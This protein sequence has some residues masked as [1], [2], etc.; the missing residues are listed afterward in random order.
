MTGSRRAPTLAAALLLLA[1]GCEKKAAAPVAGAEWHGLPPLAET[2]PAAAA[3]HPATGAMPAGHPPIGDSP[4]E[5]AP[6]P[7]A[8]DPQSMI[9]GVLRLD[10]KVKS[11]VA[12]GDTIFMVARAAD[13]SGAPGPILAVKKLNASGWPLA[14]SLDGRDAMTAG[15]KLAGEVIVSVRVD[16]DGDAMTKNP[17]DVTGVSRPIVVPADR[18]V[19]TLDTTL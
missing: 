14:F 4:S 2:A 12:A 3:T 1:C 6:A 7:T 8:F 9:S 19:I 13:P 11:H 17:G 16:K 10:D 15:T 5:A 18:V